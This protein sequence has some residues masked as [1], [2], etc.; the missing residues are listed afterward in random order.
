MRLPATSQRTSTQQKILRAA[1]DLVV[2]AGFANL[3]IAKVAERAGIAY[4]NL[5]YHFPT[6]DHLVSSVFDFW[7]EHWKSDLMAKIQGVAQG[8]SSKPSDLVSVL[9]SDAMARQK[10]R[11]STELWA[12]SNHDPKLTKRVAEIIDESVELMTE[13][14]G[15]NSTHPNAAELRAHLY[16]LLTFSQGVSVVWGGRPKG[17]SKGQAVAEIARDTIVA[18]IEGYLRRA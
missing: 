7:A 15:V 3:T 4:G 5:T 18:K 6:R 2:D 11:L 12:A 16:F 10:A 8:K 1:I 13:T 17:C 9:V 14:L